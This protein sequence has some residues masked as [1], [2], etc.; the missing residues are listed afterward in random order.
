MV[1][2]PRILEL[3]APGWEIAG[4]KEDDFSFPAGASK[5]SLIYLQDFLSSQKFLVDSGASVTVFPSPPSTSSS[6]VK[7]AIV[8]VPPSPA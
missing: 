4:R 6:G 5:S 3:P 7:L 8:M 2:S 1:T